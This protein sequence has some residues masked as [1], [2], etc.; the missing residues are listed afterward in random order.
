MNIEEIR[1]K[2][3]SYHNNK[4]V[5]FTGRDMSILSIVH[6]ELEGESV[7]LSCSP[8]VVSALERLYKHCVNEA[9]TTGITLNDLEHLSQK[10][11]WKLGKPIGAKYS[12]SKDGMLENVLAVL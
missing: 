9:P 1:D 3:I 12:K 11:L 4:S 2:V 6:K 7:N 10:E 8:C 5:R